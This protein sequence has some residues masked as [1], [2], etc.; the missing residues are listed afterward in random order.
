VRSLVAAAEGWS[1]PRSAIRNADDGELIAFLEQTVEALLRSWLIHSRGVRLSV[2]ESVSNKSRW[3]E[4]KKFIEQYG[5]DLFTQRFMNLG[6]LRAILHQGVDVWLTSLIEDP[7]NQEEY[8]LLA[9]LDGRLPREEATRWLTVAMEAVVENYAEY[10]DY[11]STTTQSDR[12]EMLYTLLDYL[13]LRA[14]YDRVAWNLQPVVL[15][16]EVLVRSGHDEAAEVWRSAV[17]ERTAEIA[18]E[19]LKRF[20]RLNRKYGMR[21]PSVADRLGERFIRPLVVDRL[22][23]LIR[24][25]MEQAPGRR[26]PPSSTGPETLNA[27]AKLEEGIEQFTRRVSGA[28]FDVPPWL[29][30]L[31]QE[32]DRVLSDGPEDE[33]LPDPLLSVAQIRLSREE[34]RR[35]VK[36]MG[37]E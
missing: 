28:G 12:G 21:L 35:Q 3:M 10:V 16:H 20:N 24:P 18:D 23:A 32:V 8:R 5:H 29:E 22:R 19:H 30:A 14:S 15:A 2:L 13:R 1:A 6:N 34:V 11:N 33:E 17:G 25:A 7:S 4:I 27:F 36:T 26:R 9:E 31:E 37:R